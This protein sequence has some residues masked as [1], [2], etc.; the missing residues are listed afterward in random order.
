[1]D[2]RSLTRKEFIKLTFTLVGGGVA[3]AACGSSSNSS[4]NNPNSCGDPL[5]ETQLPDQTGHTHT[6]T[7]PASQ[8]SA[9][10]DQT[11]TTST[12]ASHT[13]TVTL[14]SAQLGTI[15]GGGSVTVMSSVADAGTQFEHS[16][17]YQVSCH[18]VTTDGGSDAATDS[19]SSSD[20]GAQDGAGA[21]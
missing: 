16:H 8:L 10:T 5:P 1:M 2:P 21:G 19:S 6:V 20:S 15:K 17:M 14:T 18:A 11:F 7:V 13:H 4:N 12:V 9:T 3:F